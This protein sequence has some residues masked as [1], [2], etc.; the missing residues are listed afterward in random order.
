MAYKV[1]D[2]DG[3]IPTLPREMETAGKKCRPFLFFRARFAPSRQEPGLFV[4]H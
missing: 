3:W 4:V 2:W 1:A